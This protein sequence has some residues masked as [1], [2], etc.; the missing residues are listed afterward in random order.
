[1][2]PEIAERAEHAS[3][4]ALSMGYGVSQETIRGIPR[5]SALAL[6]GSFP[7]RRRRDRLR[8][9]PG[10]RSLLSTAVRAPQLT[11]ERTCRIVALAGEAPGTSGRPSGQWSRRPAR[12][13]DEVVKRGVVARISPRRTARLLRTG[14]SSPIASAPG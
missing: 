10:V 2:W 6:P 4:R 12:D 5:R 11:P 8:P 14:F 7:E 3:L 13:A 9:L 1:L